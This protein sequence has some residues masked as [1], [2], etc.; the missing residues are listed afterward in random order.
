MKTVYFEL[1]VRFPISSASCLHSAKIS[2][3]SGRPVVYL[4]SSRSYLAKNPFSSTI[5][6]LNT[7]TKTLT[8][9][10]FFVESLLGSSSGKLGSLNKCLNASIRS[11]LTFFSSSQNLIIFFSSS[12]TFALLRFKSGCSGRNV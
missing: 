3:V 8:S 12:L 6:K 4:W 10:W 5:T 11:P 9:L 1:Y 7:L 2:N